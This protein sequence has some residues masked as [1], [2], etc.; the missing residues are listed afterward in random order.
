MAANAL[1]LGIAGVKKSRHHCMCV[2]PWPRE[3]PANDGGEVG[4][5][6]VGDACTMT[7]QSGWGSKKF[8]QKRQREFVF[9]LD[10]VCSYS[11]GQGKRRGR[12]NATQP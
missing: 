4:G 3:R 9:A 1:W 11:S 6:C 2:L 7:P 8:L 10:A 5:V 12:R